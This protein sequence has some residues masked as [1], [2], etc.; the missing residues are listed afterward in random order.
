[1]KQARNYHAGLAAEDCVLREYQS[2]GYL[3]ITRRFRQLQGEIDLI[4]R[5][6][7][8]VVFVE[9]KKS[10]DFDS[11]LRRLTSAQI[12]RIFATASAFLECQ[13]LGQLTD[14]R[15]DL[16]LVDGNGSVNIMENALHE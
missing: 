6:H 2:A 10:R 7:N 4:F 5:Q 11:A 1:M 12:S 13:P 3:L 15:F 9:V 16:A 8:L 14:I